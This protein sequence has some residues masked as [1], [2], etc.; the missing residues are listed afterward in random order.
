MLLNH[1]NLP[2]AL[3]A[4]SRDYRTGFGSLGEITLSAIG[5]KRLCAAL[6]MSFRFF[7]HQLKKWRW[8]FL[9]QLQHRGE[10]VPG[11]LEPPQG[12]VRFNEKSAGIAF[13]NRI[14][15]LAPTHRH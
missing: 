2:A 13:L 10:E 11:F 1:K 7:R 15:Q 3:P 9:L 6:L 5:V 4:R 8:Q 14:S 12:Q